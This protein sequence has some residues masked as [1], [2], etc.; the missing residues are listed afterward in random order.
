MLTMTFVQLLV[1]DTHQT[2]DI[3]FRAYTLYVAV[4]T[5][6]SL[7]MAFFPSTGSKQL[8][9]NAI[10][11]Y[12]EELSETDLF[13]FDSVDDCLTKSSLNLRR[14]ELIFINMSFIFQMHFI[15]VIWSHL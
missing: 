13:Y 4:I 3:L 6:L 8:D 5:A 14:N 11:K 1:R 9:A 15:H 2:R 7:F 10:S 12:C